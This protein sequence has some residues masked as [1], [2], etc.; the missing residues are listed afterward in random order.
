[1]YINDLIGP[2]T[3]TADDAGGAKVAELWQLIR[4]IFR[5]GDATEMAGKQRAFPKL[6]REEMDRED[7]SADRTAENEEGG[8]DRIAAIE[9]ERCFPKWFTARKSV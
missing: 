2:L 5:A 4:R 8:C 7:E 9:F 6:R 3:S 1:M